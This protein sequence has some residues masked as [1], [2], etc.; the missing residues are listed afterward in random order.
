[1]AISHQPNLSW[2]YGACFPK[3][4]L[5]V[6]EPYCPGDAGDGLPMGNSECIPYFALLAPMAFA[7]PLKLSLSQPYLNFIY[8]LPFRFLPPPQ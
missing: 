2:S 8:L 7:L 5:C 3:L 4:A 6:I 1:M